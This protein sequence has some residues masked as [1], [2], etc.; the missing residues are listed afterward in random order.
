MNEFDLHHLESRV[1]ALLQAHRRLQVANR[2]L[3]AEWQAMAQR[4]QEL[5]SRME[6]VVARLKALEQQE[7][8]EA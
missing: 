3:N 7:P 2:T 5:K 1:E 6:A 4:N 8:E